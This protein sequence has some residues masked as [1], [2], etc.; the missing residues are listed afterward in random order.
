MLPGMYDT[1]CVRLLVLVGMDAG[2]PMIVRP[3]RSQGHPRV[4]ACCAQYT[5]TEGTGLFGRVEAFFFVLSL[6]PFYRKVY[7]CFS[8]GM[9]YSRCIWVV[10][11]VSTKNRHQISDI[12]DSVACFLARL[13]SLGP[14]ALLFRGQNTWN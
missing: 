1:W 5:T 10:T 8:T 13:T 6:N 9:Y 4:K 12:K 11:A 3:A 2:V 14:T 7:S